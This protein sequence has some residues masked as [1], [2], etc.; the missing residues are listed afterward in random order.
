MSK[1]E[2]T[3]KTW[4]PIV[5]CRKVSPGCLNCYAEMMSARLAGQARKANGKGGRKANYLSVVD[6]RG[7][8]NG[9]AIVVPDAFDDPLKWRKPRMVFVNSMSDLFH[10]HVDFG[11]LTDLFNV[12]NEAS[13][14]TFQVLTKR[15]DRMREFTA[16]KC[17]G[18][19]PHL[20]ENIWLGVSVENRKHGLPRIDHLRH[21]YAAVR[22]LSCEPL[23]EDLGPLDLS[24][25]DWVIVGGESGPRARPMHPRWAE[26][27]RDQCIDQG[28][29]F[30]FKQWGEWS[31]GSSRNRKTD[32]AMLTDGTMYSFPL[33][34]KQKHL[35]GSGGWKPGLL[36]TII[37]RRGK[38]RTG[39][40]LDGRT[41]DEMPTDARLLRS[42]P[43]RSH[44]VDPR[45]A[46]ASDHRTAP[47]AELVAPGRS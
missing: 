28:I 30:F 20:G 38:K 7:R 46:A 29:P 24:G 26:K 37:A 15:A 25:I 6:G 44:H 10:E 35:Q 43:D 39:R 12:M 18:V 17:Y 3:E 22:F 42:D 33:K 2:W 34:P 23:L 1:I 40:L 32:Q 41:W 8:F 5:G 19:M 36:P 14:H 13:R 4:N 11:T 16:W 47:A 27:I 31:P 9:K 45:A 21:S